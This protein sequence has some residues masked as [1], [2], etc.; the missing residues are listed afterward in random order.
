MPIKFDEDFKIYE[1]DI[2][3]DEAE[4][5]ALYKEKTKKTLQPAQSERVMISIIAYAKN[6]VMLRFQECIKNLLLP[7]AKGIWLDILGYLVGCLRLLATQSVSTLK[8]KLYEVF[9]FDKILPK[10][11]EVETSDGEAIFTT[12][13]DLVIPAGETVG[14][15]KIQ[16]VQ[17]GSALNYK[18]GE[19][20][21][22]LNNYEFVESVEN[23]T[24]CTGGTDDEN[25]DL[26]R[27]RIASAPEHYSTAG[28]DEAYK[29]FI[30]SAHKDIL[31]VCCK[32][33]DDDV[34]IELNGVT[35]K[36]TSGKIETET[37]TAQINYNKCE[38]QITF[39]VKP[40]SFKIKFPKQ[41]ELNYYILTKDGEASENILNT[42]AD[43]VNSDERRPLTDYVR[44][45]SAVRKNV[46]FS[47]IVYIKRDADFD[48]V[49]DYVLEKLN[50][51]SN[52]LNKQLNQE[53]LP[54][55]LYKLIGMVSGVYDV[56]LKNFE[57][58]YADS[59]EFLS[60]AI[61][62]DI[63]FVRAAK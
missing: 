56:D 25:D 24:D 6:L 10:G 31:D 59:N 3:A 40:Q 13:E 32:K 17:A 39:T 62:E 26:Y 4:L 60:L 55:D 1:T 33:P 22:L 29:Y 20:T 44:Y 7:Y 35:Y 11:T 14:Y 61:G 27:E 9:S 58:V 18:A 19:I 41:G 47:P 45:F 23:I 12:T 48:S 34:T 54:L 46:S 38:C 21:T 16:S 42:V 53:I 50:N 2:E 63:Q 15:V 57:A 43:Y 49:K 28:P 8:V 36:E 5:A 37:M 52:E 30:K 51:F